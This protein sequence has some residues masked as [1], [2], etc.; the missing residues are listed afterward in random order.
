MIDYVRK[1]RKISYN[2]PKRPPITKMSPLGS[3]NSVRLTRERPTI[4]IKR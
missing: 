1:P 3:E 2:H 4:T